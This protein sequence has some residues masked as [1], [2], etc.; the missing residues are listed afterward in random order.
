[1]KIT[2]T[3]K[4]ATIAGL[5]MILSAGALVAAD[6]E[7][8]G[9]LSSKDYK[10][11]TEAAKGGTTEIELGQLAT[12]KGSTDQTRR[13]GER[14]VADHKRAH[15]ELQ[16]IASKKGA[17]LPSQLSHSENS[18]MSHLQKATGMD[19]D[20]AYAKHMVK[21]HETDVKEFEDGAKNLDDPELR[22]FAQKTLPTLQEHLRMARNLEAQTKP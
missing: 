8:R 21:D 1:M 2:N 18:E 3:I 4:L 15:E 12:Q 5:A 14:M 9:Q 7:N 16:G 20:K 11:V 17:T 22:A 13:F 10:F 6:T 19:F